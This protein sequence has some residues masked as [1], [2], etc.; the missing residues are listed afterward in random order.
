MTIT[1]KG[2]KME[3]TKIF[4]LFMAIDLSCNKF[5]GEIPKVLGNLTRLQ[6]LN[7]S[8][9]MLTGPIPQAMGYLTSLEVLDLSHNKFTG[10]IPWQLTHL[11]F[12]EVFN[13]SNNNLTGPIPKGQQFDTFESSS[14]DGN[15][16]LC[17]MALS[18]KCDDSESEVLPP[19]LT[20]EEE[21]GFLANFGWK[22][23]LL[24]Y[25]CGFLVGV[26]IGIIAFTRKPKWFI[27]D[28]SNHT[29][30]EGKRG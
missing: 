5:E 23:V 28:L 7:L 29:T 15:V 9:N 8:N 30:K 25:G 3:Y 12:L 19:S 27:K 4:D 2:Q 1:N 10:R 20:L 22:I 14:F 18:K 6:L 16:G 26:V 24:G 11:N 21:S 13:V 17:G